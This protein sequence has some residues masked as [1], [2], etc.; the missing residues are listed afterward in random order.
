MFGSRSRTGGT[1]RSS[2]L[3]HGAQLALDAT[4]VSPVTR[5]L[6]KR[7]GRVRALV[8]GDVFRRLVACAVAQAFQSACLPFQYG[9]GDGSPALGS[10]ASCRVDPL[11]VVCSCTK[12]R[13][14]EKQ[15]KKHRSGDPH[16]RADTQP[17]WAVDSAT[18]RK[19]R[20]TYP[21][22]TQAR[23]CRLVVVGVEIGGCLGAEAARVPGA[24]VNSLDLFADGSRGARRGSGQPRQNA[25]LPRCRRLSQVRPPLILPI[26]FAHLVLTQSHM[27]W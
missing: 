18:R 16:P 8:V 1:L 20:D 22:L 2:P 12:A 5:A 27:H 24:A 26:A 3:W 19:R 10:C 25:C 23:H 6:R 11:T 9:L 7:N 4:I 17:G 15:Q 14:K 21:E 13:A